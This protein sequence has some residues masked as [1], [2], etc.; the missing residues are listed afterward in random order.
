MVG[1]GLCVL[2][3]ATACSAAPARPVRVRIHGHLGRISTLTV[4][5]AAKSRAVEVGKA[6][7]LAEAGAG[8]RW[9]VSQTE[10]G[11]RLRCAV[12]VGGRER[13]FEARAL[14][15]EAGEGG[16]LRVAVGR[17]ERVYPE[18]IEIQ[19]G[20]PGWTVVNEAPRELYLQGVVAAEVS[21][22]WHPEALKAL[23]VAARSYTERNR[24]RH[25]PLFDVCDTTHCREAVGATGGIVALHD[26]LPI[27]AVYSA[28]CGGRTQTVQDAWGSRREI[29]YLQSILDAPATG[30]PEYCAINPKHA[31]S[32]TLTPATL[33][34][35]LN[36]DAAT[37]VGT[38]RRIEAVAANSSGRIT[39]LELL[40]GEAEVHPVTD[41]LPCEMAEVAGE[42]AGFTDRRTA[43]AR[44]TIRQLPISRFRLM[45]GPTAARGSML[46]IQP[47]AN[48]TVRVEGRGN[49][50][51]VGLCQY[52]T[53]GMAARY[54]KT[55]E[56]ILCHYYRGITLGPLPEA[57][58]SRR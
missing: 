47:L 36:R 10:G 26:G 49:G 29:R 27:D 56:E 33:Q 31:W 35:I 45:L 28:D 11:S 15:I 48:G 37:R 23:A 53:Q 44:L 5:V 8:A 16:T 7:V 57:V 51:G 42:S 58:A 14:R 19:S 22:R 1:T 40:G 24:G 21:E 13:A 39:A 52:G 20:S 4:T 9:S 43:P 50:H 6:R 2:A 41:R 54:G 32:L 30:G 34:Q 17:A 12:V 46:L 25:G 3:A 38:L 18:V 55:W